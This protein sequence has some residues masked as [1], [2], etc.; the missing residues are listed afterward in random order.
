MDIQIFDVLQDYIRMEAVIALADHKKGHYE[1]GHKYQYDLWIMTHGSIRFDYENHTY[2][3]QE[4]D[5]FFIYPNIIYEALVLSE[6]AKFLYARF[7]YSLDNVPSALDVYPFSGYIPVQSY[8]GTMLEATLSQLLNSYRDHQNKQFMSGYLLKQYF[9]ILMARLFEFRLTYSDGISV[10][11]N[12]YTKLARLLPVLE[13]LHSSIKANYST[14]DLALIIGMSEKYFIT[15]FRDVLGLTPHK[16]HTQ[17]KMQRAVSLISEQRH[18]VRE[19]SDQLGY[20]DAYNFS[21]A[22]KKH[23]G[24]APSKYLNDGQT[25]Q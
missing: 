5:L 10:K 22:F 15:Y 1:K 18:T 23:Y 7:D 24:I 6:S 9:S 8:E 4:G 16:Y 21:T 12:A 19:I 17:I 13:L 2:I 14:K 25:Y 20:C 11:N 3:L